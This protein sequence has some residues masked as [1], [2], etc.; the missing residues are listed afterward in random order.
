MTLSLYLQCIAMYVLGQAVHLFLLKIPNIQK[1]ATAANYEFTFKAYWK[2]DWYIVAG[3]LALGIMLTIGVD[4]LIS[5]KPAILNIVKWFFGFVG[6]S[7]STLVMSKYG[8]F[9]KRIMNVIDVK[10]NIA[11]EAIGIEKTIPAPEKKA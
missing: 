2:S 5:W 6:V 7:G 4:Q 10:T 3:T 9:E 11:D 1:R 8:Q